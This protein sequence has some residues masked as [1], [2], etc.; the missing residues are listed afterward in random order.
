MDAVQREG[1]GARIAALRKERGWS[2]EKLAEEAGVSPRTV[3]SVEKGERSP[4]PAKLR[5]IL[6]ALD[7]AE[8]QNGDLVIE[9]MPE[10]VAVFLRVAAQRLCVLDYPARSQV[11]ADI[12][13]RL[14]SEIARQP[15][16]EG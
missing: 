6:D 2:Q 8:P 11:L 3:F 7:V 13:P 12:Y 14:L 4:Q 10:D 1:V 16:D 9:G 15:G 5:A